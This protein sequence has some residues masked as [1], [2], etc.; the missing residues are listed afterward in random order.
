MVR[1]SWDENCAKAGGLANGI[2]VLATSTG[3]L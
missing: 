2:D 3:V 1:R